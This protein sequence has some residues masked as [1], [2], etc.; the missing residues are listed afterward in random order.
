[1]DNSPKRR[2]SKDNPY[3]L[4]TS[5]NKSLMIVSFKDSNNIIQNIPI[6][7]EQY[8]LFNKFELEDLSYLN[9]VD[10]H[11]DIREINDYIIYNLL[12][13]EN[14]SLEEIVEEKVLNNELYRLIE[15]L[16]DKQKKRLKMYYFENMKLK[17][18]ADAEKTSI[19]AIQYSL[20]LAMEKLREIMKNKKI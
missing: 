19:R 9:K 15:K 12:S 13:S 16:S 7:K 20:D 3:R 17:D 18:I 10:R 8:E 5:S 14:K 2:K 11:I 4:I 6:T 1:M